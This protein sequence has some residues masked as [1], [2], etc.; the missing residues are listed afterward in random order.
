VSKA[1]ED[2]A[3]GYT[4][5][6]LRLAR[7]WLQHECIYADP[8][9]PEIEKHDESNVQSLAAFRAEARRERDAELEDVWAICTWYEEQYTRLRKLR[10]SERE[11]AEELEKQLA[12]HDCRE[13]RERVTKKVE[14]LTR[15]RDEA[16]AEIERVKMEVWA[17]GEYQSATE[18]AEQAEAQRDALAKALRQVRAL[19]PAVMD[20][21]ESDAEL[22]VRRAAFESIQDAYELTQPFGAALAQIEGKQ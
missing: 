7:E 1:D 9:D 6:D 10:R 4:E 20:A 11:A 19:I 13:F 14:E 16:R 12:C 21:L 8:Y 3:R 22:N 18:R 15:E 5:E 17:N 2:A